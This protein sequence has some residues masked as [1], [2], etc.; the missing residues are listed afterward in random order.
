MATSVTPH[1][2]FEGNAEQAL[3]F[4]LSVFKDSRIVAM[5]KYG[6]GE[7]GKEGTIKFAV[8]QLGKQRINCTDS[9]VHHEFT[10]TPA[11]SFFVDCDSLVQQ[12]RLYAALGEGGKILM[13][14]DNYGFSE[15]FAWVNDRFGVSWQ[16]N[17][18]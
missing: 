2:M 15:R 11:F 9:P 3:Q 18:P 8:F 13:P 4:Y 10:F 16:L 6:P 12:D 5:D 7:P 14:L 1:L 17:K